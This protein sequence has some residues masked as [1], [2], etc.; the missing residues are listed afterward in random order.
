MLLMGMTPRTTST[1]TRSEMPC[2]S[3]PR[4]TVVPRGPRSILTTLF[5]GIL[6]PA[7]SESPISTMRSPAL[8]PA[9]SLGPCGMT[10]S[11]M[12]VSVAML[13]TTPMPSNS[14]SRGSFRAPHFRGGDIDRMGV[15]FLDQHRNDV[16]G[17]RVH[18]HRV[19]ILVLDQ[20]ERIGEFVVGQ[21]HAAE[22][23]LELR[24]GGVAAQILART[25]PRTTPRPAA[26]RGLRVSSF[27]Y[28]V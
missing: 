28:I 19:D 1:S 14:P 7:T 22:H 4:R 10:F 5:W 11:T 12:T 17:E 15:Q 27:L 13:K 24:R 2:R 8:T 18:R 9:L 26:G 20:R 21:R 25:R 23:A 3:R 6:R 16:F